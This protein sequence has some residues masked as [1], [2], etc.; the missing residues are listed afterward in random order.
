MTCG[1]TALYFMFCHLMLPQNLLA[2]STTHSLSHSFSGQESRIVWLHHL[3][4]GLL[5]L[6]SE[7]RLGLQPLRGLTGEG[8]TCKPPPVIVTGLS[9]WLNCWSEGLSSVLADGQQTLSLSSVPGHLGLSRV[10]HNMVAVYTQGGSCGLVE[11]ASHH[12]CYILLE[13]SH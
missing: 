2:S 10:P 6:L 3:L 12:F 4:R 8:F 7:C 11:V 13:A 5:Q 1:T 9:S